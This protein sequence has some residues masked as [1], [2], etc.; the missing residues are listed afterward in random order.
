M[1][2]AVARDIGAASIEIPADQYFF[3][4]SGIEGW[5]IPPAIGL[6]VGPL[7][8]VFA[9]AAEFPPVLRKL[10]VLRKLGQLEGSEGSLA[11]WL[12]V[13][14]LAEVTMLAAYLYV[15]YLFFNKKRRNS[16]VLRWAYRGVPFT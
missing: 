9:M 1:S 3:G 12:V 6:V 4:P 15:A 11:N 10:A 5:L 2:R 7:V 14:M 16:G 13:D 8:Q